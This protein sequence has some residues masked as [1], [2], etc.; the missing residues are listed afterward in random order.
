LG[1]SDG[2]WRLTGID[3]EGCDLGLGDQTAR[4]AFPGLVTNAGDL[5]RIL[6]DFAA[7]AR[8]A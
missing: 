1:E 6:V 4:L 8:A 2:P 5:R 3:P 7:K